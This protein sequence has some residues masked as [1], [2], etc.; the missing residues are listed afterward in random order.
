MK[1]QSKHEAISGFEPPAAYG[2]DES[3]RQ[4]GGICRATLYKAAKKGKIKITKFGARS[5]ITREEIRR[6]A[7]EGW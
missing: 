7:Q 4:L 1:S 3:C 6:V 5:V 2:I